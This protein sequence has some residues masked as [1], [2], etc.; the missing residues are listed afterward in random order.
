MLGEQRCEHCGMNMISDAEQHLRAKKVGP[1]LTELD[2]QLLILRTQGLKEASPVYIRKLAKD[3]ELHQERFPGIA[4]LIQEA[5]TTMADYPEQKPAQDPT[6][7]MNILVLIVL[8]A[9]AG[10]GMYAGVEGPVAFFLWISAGGW[11]FLGLWKY[12]R[13]KKREQ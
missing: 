3:L 10:I 9:I 8:I 4:P 13:E 1:M 6:L 7:I 5:Q 2:N 11:A 12:M